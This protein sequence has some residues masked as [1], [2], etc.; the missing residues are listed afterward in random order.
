[1]EQ[2]EKK[3]ESK[4]TI[5]SSDKTE[6]A[7]FDMKQPLFNSMNASKSFNKTPKNKTLYHA[8]MKSL[9]ED[10]NAMDQGVADLIKQKKRPHDDA[11]KDE[12]PP[13]RSDQGLRRRKTS[14]DTKPSK[15]AKPTCTSKSITKSQPKSTGKS[16]QAEEKK[17]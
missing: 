5:R 8:L 4:Y 14:K 12:G 10:E 17:W 16:A 9:I 11:N 3:P 15:K 2:A 1:M 6:L 13:T 7:E